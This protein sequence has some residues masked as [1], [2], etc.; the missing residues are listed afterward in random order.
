MLQGVDDYFWSMGSVEFISCQIDRLSGE[1]RL[2]ISGDVKD[3]RK[4]GDEYPCDGGDKPVVSI[5]EEY[6]P[7]TD[8]W[9]EMVGG[10]LFY[11][12]VLVGGAYF[13]RQWDKYR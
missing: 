3:G 5:S 8:P 6:D 1:S 10:A 13:L 11:V 2:G 7:D 9:S 4:S 12:C